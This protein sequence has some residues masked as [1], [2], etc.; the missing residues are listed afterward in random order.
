MTALLLNSFSLPVALPLLLAFRLL[1]ASPLMLA[2]RLLAASPLLLALVLQCAISLMEALALLPVPVLT[3][4][5]TAS[6][7]QPSPPPITTPVQ[8]HYDFST[9]PPPTSS[10]A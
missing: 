3:S 8:P 7:V 5:K 1:A 9:P 6:M 4:R 2:F 10:F